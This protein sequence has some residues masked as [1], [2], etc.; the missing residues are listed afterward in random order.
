M[1]RDQSDEKEPPS[2]VTELLNAWQEGRQGAVDELMPLVYQELRKL[3]RS[4]MRNERPDHTLQATA[5]VNEA[6]LRLMGQKSVQWEN[7]KHFF[8]IASQLMR[9]ILVDHARKRTAGKRGGADTLI[10]FEEDQVAPTGQPD[11]VELD[12]ALDALTKI[13]PDQAK[14]VEFRYFT[15]LTIDE[16]AKVLELSPATVKREWIVAKAWLRRELRRGNG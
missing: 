3:A 6:Y 2:Q 9:R 14:L 12:A 7:R 1:T 10:P 4:Y 16:T 11:L 5:L 8:G 13:D 15:G